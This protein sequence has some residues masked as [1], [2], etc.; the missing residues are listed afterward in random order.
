[1]YQYAVR[2]HGENVRVFYLMHSAG[3]VRRTVTLPWTSAE[4]EAP[5]NSEFI[6]LEADGPTGTRVKCFVQYRRVEGEFGGNGSGSLS[7][8]TTSPDED[9]TRC[10]VDSPIIS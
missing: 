9:E 10:A 8:Y 3:E 4:F 5:A 1:V 2:G 6:R 7:Q